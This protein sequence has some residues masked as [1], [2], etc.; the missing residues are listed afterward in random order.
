LAT[1]FL[2][3]YDGRPTVP[4]PYHAV[5]AVYAPTAAFDDEQAATLAL[6]AEQL[7]LCRVAGIEPCIAGDFNARLDVGR[8]GTDVVGSFARQDVIPAGMVA[9][10]ADRLSA[11]VSDSDTAGVPL[12]SLVGQFPPAEG[13]RR[14]AADVGGTWRHSGGRWSAID[15]VLTS[16]RL[17]GR[18]SAAALAL[19]SRVSVGIL[20]H[21]AIIVRFMLHASRRQVQRARFMGPPTPPPFSRDTEG[22]WH[23]GG[24]EVRPLWRRVGVLRTTGIGWGSAG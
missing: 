4:G 24:H 17:R 20:D 5:I 7:R 19:R 15:H 16:D 23:G 13:R 18:T 8:M 14:A 12:Y 9:R 2:A 21:V 22:Q 6:A 3:G 1:S 10:A 11:F